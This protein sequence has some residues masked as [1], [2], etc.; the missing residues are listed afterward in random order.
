MA[1]TAAFLPVFAMV[2]PFAVPV[3]SP[4]SSPSGYHRGANTGLPTT[5]AKLHRDAEGA[6]SATK[7]PSVLGES[8]AGGSGSDAM[9]LPEPAS[10][11]AV[12]TGSTGPLWAAYCANPSPKATYLYGATNV[13]AQA[14]NASLT[15]DLSGSGTITVLRST[16]ANYDNQVSYFATGYDTET[17]QPLSATG[18]GGSFLG[19]RY[20]VGS[21]AA[22]RVG[23]SW[24]RSWSHT[25]AY[26]SASSPVPVTTYRSPGKLGL[27]IIDT[28]LAT[29]APLNAL[30]GNVSHKGPD[31]FVRHVLV[32]RS[33]SSPVTSAALVAYGNFSPTASRVA[34]LPVEDMGCAAQANLT[35][36]GSYSTKSGLATVSWHGVDLVTG[37]PSSAAVSMGFAGR[38]ASEQIGTDSQDPLAPPGPK[39]GYEE[40]SSPPY[41]LSGSRL[42]TG[43]VTITLEHPLS[44]KRSGVATARLIIGAARTT[45]EAAD[46]VKSARASSWRS[47]LQ[48]VGA[49]WHVLLANA[50]MPRTTDARVLAVAKRSVI[51]MLLAV[52]PLTGAIVASADT[53]GPYGEDWVRDGSFINA[54]LDANGFPWLATRQDLF[55]AANQSSPTHPIPSVPFGNWPMTMYVTG[56]PGG[57]IPYE[58]DE[59]GYGAWTLWR[60]ARYVAPAKRAAYLHQVFPAISRAADYLSACQDPLNGFQCYASEDDNYEP[61]QTLHGALPDLLALQSA[62][63][64]AKVLK[65]HNPLVGE[66][67]KRAARLKAAIESLYDP[68]QHAYREGP[69]SSSALPVSFEDGGLMLWPTHLLAYRN[70]TMQ[71]EAAQTQASMDASFKDV[72]GSYEGVALLGLCHAWK[73]TDPAKLSELAGT[74]SYMASTLTSP[75]GLFGEA[76]RRWGDGR[77]TPL[78]DQ[79]HVWES[80]LFDMSATCIDSST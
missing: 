39:D 52:D 22:A 77:I 65:V 80:A 71:G 47:E 31:A 54:A 18:N 64:A 37:K 34:Y 53:Q 8:L 72:S 58:I 29:A 78:N 14:G 51:T 66:W 61:T 10:P 9:A 73:R 17:G 62:L 57:P 19:L 2:L 59:T 27:K 1:M 49:A 44:F 42:A 43:Q 63:S 30:D 48:A 15:V 45:R 50:K 28:D 60:Q 26:L 21:G 20:V 25:Q 79:P 75:T 6:L 76:W 46:Q 11:R 32:L 12:S 36:L 3:V 13:N 55:Y 74:L 23:F 5:S 40:L 4:T 7:D 35:K 33:K 16:A 70:P 68:A 24:L 41:L 69:T 56:Q 38:T 67:S